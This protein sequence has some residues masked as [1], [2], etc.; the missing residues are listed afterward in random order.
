[1]FPEPAPGR[2]RLLAR[3]GLAGVDP[4]QRRAGLEPRPLRSSSGSTCSSFAAACRGVRL[5]DPGMGLDDLTERPERDPIA[6]GQ[7]APLPPAHQLG[8]LVDVAKSSAHEP[9]LADARL[10]DEG[11]ELDSESLLRSG[12]TP[13]SGASSPAAADEQGLLR[14]D[15]VGAEAR[16]RLDAADTGRPARSSPSPR[17]ARAARSEDTLC[18]RGT[19]P[20]DTAKPSTGAAACI[21]DAVFTTSPATIPSP[22][23]GRA[24]E[25]HHRLPG[26]DAD[27]DLKLQ[28]RLL[29]V[30]LADRLQDP[31]ARP[32][33]PLRRRPRARPARRRPPSPRRR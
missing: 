2:E 22:S 6:V 9:A 33:R 13:R 10:A 24:S 28:L 1:M 15:Q 30:Q 17:P 7:A 27:P 16:T 23:S 32:D 26:V 11:H 12:R 8:A 25:R 19:S 29:L 20:P 18:L 3:G 31:Q 4:E 5:E 14:P 21:R